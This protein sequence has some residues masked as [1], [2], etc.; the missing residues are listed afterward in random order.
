MTDDKDPL[1]AKSL[2]L[3][4]SREL[5]E[6][7]ALLAY[8]AVERNP[9]AE[10]KDRLMAG[11]RPV[12]TWYQGKRWLR[13]AAAAALASVLLFV[14]W[15][16]TP[17][18]GPIL[19]A[20]Q[21]AVTVDG[22]AAAAG[23]RVSWGSVIEVSSDGEA[24]VRVDDRAGFSLSRGGRAALSRDGAA[25]SVRLFSGWLLSAV[26]TGTAYAVVTEHSRVSALGTDFIVKVR[27]A[28]AYVCI[29]HGHLGL[30]GDFPEPE[31]ASQAHGSLTEPLYKPGSEGA[32]EGHSDDAIARL[33]DLVGLQH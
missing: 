21:G 18:S 10:L 1:N 3:P 30:G 9:P 14:M 2:D 4:P 31:I 23:A 24:V 6:A 25:L 12:P 26:K 22:R 7:A 33:R 17:R 28:R 13:P 19:I 20:S 32:M 11:L 5:D 27:D 16:R 29:C 8:A 15:T